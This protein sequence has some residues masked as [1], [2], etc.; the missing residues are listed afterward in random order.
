[1][2]ETKIVLKQPKKYLYKVEVFDKKK[3]QR[4]IRDNINKKV[5]RKHP[6]PI[7]GKT[8]DCKVVLLPIGAPIYHLNNG[9]TRADQSFYINE[10][11]H[12]DNWFRDGLEN[13][14]QQNLQHRFLVD[15]AKVSKSNI[16]NELK[17]K[18]EFREESP[19]LLDV[20]GIVI[21]GNRRLASVREIY[22]ESPKKYEKFKHI[23]CAIVEQDLNDQQIKQVENNIQVKRE[24]KQEYDWISLALEIKKEREELK[25]PF[26]Q[27]AADMGRPEQSVKNWYELITL[28]EKSLKEDFK[29]EKN[30]SLVKNQ[31]QIWKDTIERAN[32]AGVRPAEKDWILKSGR[33][34]AL[35]SGKFRTRDY[36]IL[37]ALQKK[38]AISDAVDFFKKHH[39]IKNK[40]KKETDSLD[41]PL[42]DLKDS[43]K[44]IDIT[45][46]DQIPIKKKNEDIISKAVEYI[47]TKKDFS[48]AKKYASDA[49]G[50]IEAM[51]FMKYP[52]KD[53]KEIKKTLEKIVSK[54]EKIINTKLK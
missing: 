33:M 6:V 32:K 15:L 49:L 38:S 35:N 14:K 19:L 44:G 24:F 48:A 25:L 13:N 39:H 20:Y 2:S 9:R 30:Y 12:K 22:T 43:I 26:K 18:G 16:F 50:K 1:M 4:I 51:N 34:V 29:D 27:I 7:K 21:N 47:A 36:S 41:D 31:E 3:R 46:V 52:E 28:V 10:H 8:V 42:S 45:V 37:S 11:N 5:L 40:E 53:R 17:T 23:P 54:S